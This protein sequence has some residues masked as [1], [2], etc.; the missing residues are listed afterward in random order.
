M[1]SSDL[2]YLSAEDPTIEGD[3]PDHPLAAWDFLW[4]M[5]RHVDG[6]ELA[7]YRLFT[8]IRLSAPSFLIEQGLVY[9]NATHLR[10][11]DQGFP[12]ADGIARTLYNYNFPRSTL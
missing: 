2:A 3:P 4:S 11:G 7:R 6:I 10:L 9:Q 1:C 12:I 5:L 8:G